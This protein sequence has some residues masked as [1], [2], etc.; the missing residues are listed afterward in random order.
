MWSNIEAGIG[1]VAGS[2]ATLRP[3]FRR[4]INRT[5]GSS[6]TPCE[7]ITIGGSAKPKHLPFNLCSL[8]SAPPAHVKLHELRP[9]TLIDTVTT[10]KKI[11]HNPGTYGFK[12]CSGGS[13]ENLAPKHRD[14]EMGNSIYETVQI[15]VA[16]ESIPTQ[17]SSEVSRHL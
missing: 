11:K 15:T 10:A 1:I 14:A 2:L 9:D 5:M 12:D 13:E 8:S 3:L 7:L 16:E 17:T 4:Y 6:E